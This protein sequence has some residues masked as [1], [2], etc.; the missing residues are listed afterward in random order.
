MSIVL[1]PFILVM[2]SAPPE[3]R[4]T[5]ANRLARL[6]KLRIEMTTET[7]TCPD[8]ASPF[9]RSL[10][11]PGHGFAFEHRVAVVRP[12]LLDEK[13]TDLP[14]RG[15]V[16][17][18]SSVF[19]GTFVRRHVQPVRGGYTLYAV[20]EGDVQAGVFRAAPLLQVLDIHIHDSLNPQLNLLRLFDEYDVTLVRDLPEFATYVVTVDMPGSGVCHYEFDLNANGTP[21]RFKTVLDFNQNDLL[22]ATWEMF[23]LETADVNGAEFPME[24][25]VTIDNPNVGG[26]TYGLHHFLVTSVAVDES[27]TAEDVR[28]VP[29]RRNAMIRTTGQDGWDERH[30]YDADGNLIN[31]ETFGGPQVL[32]DGSYVSRESLRWRWLVPTGGGAVGLAAIMAL[33]LISRPRSG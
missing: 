6:D 32:A 28:I 9:D 16:P 30:T 21:L 10:W 23:I 31:T 22:P 3:M 27:L 13:L 33:R 25:I 12:N 15:Y 11:N 1:L 29:E 7:F 18:V 5:V 4:E 8:D 19:D 14:E 17:V 26:N 2:G 24:T 20:C